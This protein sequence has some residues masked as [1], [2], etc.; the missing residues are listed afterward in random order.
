M[1][2]TMAWGEVAWFADIPHLG[3]RVV[4]TALCDIA[5]FRCAGDNV[6]AVDNKCPHKGGP[7][8]QG[9]VHG[10][11]VTYPLHNRVIDLDS[12]EAQASDFGYVRRRPVKLKAGRA[13]LALPV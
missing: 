3:S 8:S 7:L 13:P 11:T 10:H 1:K 6:F 4:A 9:I 2:A 5:L 12:G